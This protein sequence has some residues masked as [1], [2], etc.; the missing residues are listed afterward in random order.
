M[1]VMAEALSSED[2]INLIVSSNTH[3]HNSTL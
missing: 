1:A 2:K 3:V